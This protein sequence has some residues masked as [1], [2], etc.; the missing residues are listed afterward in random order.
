MCVGVCVWSEDS[1]QEKGRCPFPSAM[2]VADITNL[3]Y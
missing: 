1:L 2:L 3:G